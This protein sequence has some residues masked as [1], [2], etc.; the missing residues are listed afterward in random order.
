M[1]RMYPC[2]GRLL[3]LALLA[4]LAGC[5]HSIPPGPGA[6]ALAYAEEGRYD[7][8]SREIEL[9]VRR[10]P[11]DIVLRRQ[12]GQIYAMA[13]NTGRALGHLEEAVDLDEDDLQAWLLIG[14]LETDR[15][16][17]ADAYIAY[18]NASRVAPDE[19]RAVA[20]L[21][22][23]AERMGFDEEA[24]AAYA[25][26]AALEAELAGDTPPESR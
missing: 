16:N 18:R 25:R 15:E 24:E 5:A 17:A 2:R 19:I 13:G 22:L 10:N 21:A 14:R 11:N 9:A 6:V 8:A 12:A 20:G 7:E 26:W 1:I 23:A 4:A 3:T